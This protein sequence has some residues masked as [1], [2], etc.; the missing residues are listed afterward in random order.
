LS[1][2]DR[3]RELRAEE[4]QMPVTGLMKRLTALSREKRV[5]WLGTLAAPNTPLWVA[6]NNAN[7]SSIYTG[8]VRG[9]IPKISPLVVAIPGG[10]PTG[11]VFNPTNGFV[12]HAGNA[13]GRRSSSSTPRTARSL[14]GSRPFRR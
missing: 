12:V 11:I 13:S 6:D 1:R 4:V 7:V 5:R 3:A 2:R 9:S 14:P 10:A 8:G